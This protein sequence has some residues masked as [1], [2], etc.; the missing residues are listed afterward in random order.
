MKTSF[1]INTS[2][3]AVKAG[4]S[5][6][7]QVKFTVTNT[8][9]RAMR[10][11]AAAKPL[12]ATRRE[13]LSLTGET[14]RDLAGGATD[15]FVVSFDGSSAPAGTYPFRLEVSSSS[16]PDEDVAEGPTV[17]VDV[18]GKPTTPPPVKK[19]FPIWIIFVIAGVLLL[20]GIIVL[21]L[22]LRNRHA[23]DNSNASSTPTE[24]PAGSPSPAQL[25]NVALDKQARQSSI[26]Q[27][28]VEPS[29][30]VDGNRSGNWAEGSVTHTQLERSPWWEV[31]IGSIQTI[32]RVAIFNRTDCCPERLSD[33]YVLVSE[34]PFTSNDLNENINRP[35]VASFHAPT[36]AGS[37]TNIPIG[38]RG[39][40]VRIQLVGTNY[41]SL[42]EVEVYAELGR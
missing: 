23:N 8:T 26:Y 14:E 4:D 36:Q 17:N 29:R 41:L 15:D 1:S 24:T 35:G 12:G 33:F 18:A 37:P 13:W 31:D 38:R 11:A 21:V 10:A 6:R 9:T 27:P 28:G 34:T 16:N 25:I 30:A 39:R 5:G 42:A 3:T 20:V 2:I 40:Y 19:P 32:R 22:V 7:A